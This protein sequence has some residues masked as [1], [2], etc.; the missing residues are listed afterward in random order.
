MPKDKPGID[1]VTIGDAEEYFED[2]GLEYNIDYK[3][4]AK[5]K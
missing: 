2:L 4:L 3:D 1:K 5:E